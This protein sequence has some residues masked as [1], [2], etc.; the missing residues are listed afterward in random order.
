[1]WSIGEALVN[2][3]VERLVVLPTNSPVTGASEVLSSAKVGNLISELRE[4]YSDRIV[5][6][7]LPPDSGGGRRDDRVAAH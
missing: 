2:P 1:M 4:R 5:I 3:G 6:F 7:D